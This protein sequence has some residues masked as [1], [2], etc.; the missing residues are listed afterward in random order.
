MSSGF[1]LSLLSRQLVA[2]ELVAA[3]IQ[4]SHR[5]MEHAMAATVG[6][7]VTFRMSF[8]CRAQPLGEHGRSS[9]SQSSSNGP[10]AQLPKG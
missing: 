3:T 6:L 10:L 1:R 2:Q 4:D 5:H 8:L 7:T 9:G